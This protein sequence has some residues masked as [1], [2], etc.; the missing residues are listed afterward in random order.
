MTIRVVSVPSSFPTLEDAVVY[1]HSLGLR[2]RDRIYIIALGR[3]DS[4]RFGVVALD[5][6]GRLVTF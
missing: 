3:P 1:V 4:P 2:D 5:D 6:R